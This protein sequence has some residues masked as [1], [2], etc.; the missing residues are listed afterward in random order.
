MPAFQN[1]Q[2]PCLEPLLENALN[3]LLILRNT[4]LFPLLLRLRELM[5]VLFLLLKNSSFVPR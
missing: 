3:I 2:M 1:K 4:M 5:Q